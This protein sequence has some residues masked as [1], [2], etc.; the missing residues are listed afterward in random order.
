MHRL[1]KVDISKLNLLQL[2][3]WI[4]L[5]R[6]AVKPDIDNRTDH[7]AE[8]CEE[9]EEHG[10]TYEAVYNSKLYKQAILANAIEPDEYILD[11]LGEEYD[12]SNVMYK[13]TVSP[14]DKFDN[15]K[16]M[17][18]DYTEK[19]IDDIEKYYGKAYTVLTAEKYREELRQLVV[20]RKE[21]KINTIKV[22]KNEK[23]LLSKNPRRMLANIDESTLVTEDYIFTEEKKKLSSKD[24]RINR[25]LGFKIYYMKDVQADLDHFNIKRQQYY[26]YFDNKLIKEYDKKFFG[27]L[28]FYL[29]LDLEYAE[30][31]YNM[32]GYTITK[33]RES[34]DEILT[35]CFKHGFPLLYATVLLERAADVTTTLNAREFPNRK[36]EF[37]IIDFELD[38]CENEEYLKQLRYAINRVSK[39]LSAK[40]KSI[41]NRENK[42]TRYKKDISSYEKEKENLLDEISIIDKNIAYYQANL[43]GN[44]QRLKED[45]GKKRIKERSIASIDKEIAKKKDSITLNKNTIEEIKN[46]KYNSEDFFKFNMP[47]YDGIELHHIENVQKE[48]LVLQLKYDKTKRQPID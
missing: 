39:F 28:A 18:K 13:L 19:R 42:I 48:L 3:Y 24:N 40:Y 35:R 8:F 21:N 12:V 46:Q 26:N 9:W 15:I 41:D 4:K 32:N 27:N 11:I 29:S 16:S 44:K 34:S 38:A 37:S 47:Q 23:K 22:L 33:S 36:P 7:I 43:K 30:M 17:I 20:N 25:D 1:F 6:N 45:Q 14:N 31:L 5:C 10:K 2:A